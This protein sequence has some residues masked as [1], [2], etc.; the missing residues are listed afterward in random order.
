MQMFLKIDGI[1]GEST[2]RTHKEWIQVHSF[3]W[4]ETNAVGPSGSNGAPDVGALNLVLK[5]GISTPPI[6]SSVFTAKVFPKVELSIQ[7][8]PRGANARANNLKFKWDLYNVIIESLTFGG[9]ETGQAP[10][11]QVALVFQKCN[12]ADGAV[13]ASIDPKLIG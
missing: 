7:G 13:Q 1:K 11:D 3:S 10:A 5:S 2:D 9:S 8:T 12:I 6:A 4:S